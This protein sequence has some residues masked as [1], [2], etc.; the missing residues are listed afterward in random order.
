[1]R[2]RMAGECSAE[3][4]SPK[5]LRRQGQ[6]QQECGYKVYRKGWRKRR[7]SNSKGRESIRGHQ[8]RPPMVRLV[9]KIRSPHVPAVNL[10]AAGIPRVYAIVALSR[11][12]RRPALLVHVRSGCGRCGPWADHASAGISGITAVGSGRLE[13]AAGLRMARRRGTRAVAP[14]RGRAVPGARHAGV[15]VLRHAGEHRRRWRP[16][17]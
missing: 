9:F 8:H 10:V 15:R 2:G 12:G 6:W 16:R 1:M 3:R 5:R 14:L 4:E 13:R 17:G 11:S 7:L